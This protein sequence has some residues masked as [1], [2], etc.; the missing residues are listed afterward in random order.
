MIFLEHFFSKVPQ[1]HS[2]PRYSSSSGAGGGT[3]GLQQHQKPRRHLSLHPQPTLPHSLGFYR[4][5]LV[6]R[7]VLDQRVLGCFTAHC[8]PNAM[9]AASSSSAGCVVINT[10]KTCRCCPN[11][12][13]TPTHDSP[14]AGAPAGQA[15]TTSGALP[16]SAWAVSESCSLHAPGSS[17]MRKD[18][19]SLWCAGRHHCLQLHV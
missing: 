15:I 11:N 16:C 3:V 13:S 17:R 19:W 4:Q 12:R 5:R 6:S 1:Q 9:P 10:L 18:V 2:K 7:Q 14:P 8:C